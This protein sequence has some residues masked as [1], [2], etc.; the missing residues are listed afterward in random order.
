VKPGFLLAG[1][2]LAVS[3][4]L[5][6][7]QPKS[8]LPPGFDN[9]TP[10]PTPAPA[11]RPTAAPAAVPAQGGP[12]V[13]QPLPGT[14]PS[15][16]NAPLPSNLPPVSELEKMDPDQL[17]ELF[18]LKPKYDIPPGAQRALVKVGVIGVGEG[19][20]PSHALEGQP[21]S[22]IRAA[23][24]G[25][26]GPLVSRW[27]HIL[28]RR[29][30]ASRL[31]APQGMDPVEF[32][33]LRADLLNRMGEG[34]VARA[35]VQDV[36][37]ANYNP[38]L[39]AAAFNAYIETGDLVGI[40]PV[41]QL[42]SKLLA[43]PHWKLMDAV[44]AAFNGEGRRAESDLDKALSRGTAPR[45][46]VLL[47]Q[48][49]AGAAGEGQKS[50]TIEWDD[51]D[52]MTPWRLALSRALGIDIPDKLMPRATSTL[53]RND[54]LYP[55]TPL[56]RRV[57]AADAAARDGILSSAAMIDLYSQLWSD[58]D[59]DS[60]DKRDARQLREA[61]VA[62][63]PKARMSAMQSLWGGT[64]PEYGRQV[65]TAYAAARLPVDK[66]LADKA[67]PII[68]SMLSAGLDRNAM[69]WAGLV[70][71]GSQGWALLALA[72]PNRQGSV[73]SSAVDT[74]VGNDKS[75]DQRKSRFLLAGL[76]G[77]GRLDAGDVRSF[78]GRL[79]I[80]LDRPTRWSQAID[81]AGQ[82]R[83]PALVALLA[84]LGMQGSGWDKMTA[85]HLFH[86]V[87]ALDQAGL[88]AEARMIAAEA[89]ARG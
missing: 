71:E 43:T 58:A 72:Q 27:G 24:A 13:L 45:I 18:G 32:A 64:A 2:L 47:A 57:A 39:A 55:A 20:F 52:Q 65:L 26:T 11:P 42:N 51:V 17:D 60:G 50:V 85:R 21:A 78:S 89:V 1:V 84:G 56:L 5:V 29:A 62:S 4:T 30:L 16:V 25:T 61:Y 83:N 46:D 15:Q 14:S 53:F 48:R 12:A 22:L 70:D 44:C 87:R 75:G 35:L 86:I 37:S 88:G 10:T 40:C 82:Y 68:A 79:G 74:F 49:Y 41:E 34:A 66:D 9:P 76:A 73:P 7:A 63:D 3:S 31:N 33:A 23:L 28:L 67:A 80:D 69:R 77:L 19:G 59:T 36:D 8:L 6:L 81:M 54:V 38:Q